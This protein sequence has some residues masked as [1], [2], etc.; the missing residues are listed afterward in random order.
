MTKAKTTTKAK[1]TKTASTSNKIKNLDSKKRTLTVGEEL[2]ALRAENKVLRAEK[3]RLTQ[4]QE[5]SR[6]ADL[7]SRARRS[8]TVFIRE[9]K[10]GD[11]D[12]FFG[13]IVTKNQD[14]SEYI[15]KF[16]RDEIT[17]KFGSVYHQGYKFFVSKEEVA[18][19]AE[20]AKAQ[21]ADKTVQ[22]AAAEDA[23][24]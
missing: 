16:S 19:R 10:S 7:T 9:P 12:V 21:L 5:S 17:S 6:I 11:S 14:G 4:E 20:D 13:Y 22:S 23:A 18:K 2:K 3:E 24:C 15:H 8:K 1:A